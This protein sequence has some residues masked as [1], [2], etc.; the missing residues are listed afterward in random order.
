MGLC[1]CTT[2]IHKLVFSSILSSMIVKHSSGPHKPNCSFCTCNLLLRGPQQ[3]AD[4][5]ICLG[6]H[7]KLM[8]VLTCFQNPYENLQQLDKRLFIFS[9]IYSKK[10]SSS[11]N[12]CRTATQ[13]SDNK[14]QVGFTIFS[15]TTGTT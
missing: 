1:Y 14:C 8:K 11:L 2:I 5:H 9:H 15:S 6:W 7:P 10:V 13:G 12:P 4:L 3:E